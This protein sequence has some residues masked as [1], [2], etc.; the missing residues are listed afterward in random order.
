MGVR[1]EVFHPGSRGDADVRFGFVPDREEAAD[2]RLKAEVM[3]LFTH[4]KCFG[5][6]TKIIAASLTV[7]SLSLPAFT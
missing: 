1:C 3:M 2:L 7:V 4:A 5:S 6:A